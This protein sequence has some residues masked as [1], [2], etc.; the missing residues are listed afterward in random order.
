MLRVDSY[1]AKVH[2][3]KDYL[4]GMPDTPEPG[5]EGED[6]DDRDG[7]LVIPFGALFLWLIWL[8]PLESSGSLLGDLLRQ[9]LDVRRCW[10]LLLFGGALPHLAAG[11]RHC[12]L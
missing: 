7:N 11:R 3:I 5:Y 9:R 2:L 12:E 1:L 10:A 6:C 4:V 8:D